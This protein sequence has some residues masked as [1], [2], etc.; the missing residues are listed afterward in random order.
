MIAHIA[1]VHAMRSCTNL[2]SVQTCVL[3]QGPPYTREQVPING[4][5]MWLSRQKKIIL[6]QSKIIKVL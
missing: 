5:K 2:K 6:T 3:V 4:V 1:K